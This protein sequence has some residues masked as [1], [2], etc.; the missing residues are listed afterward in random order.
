M[1]HLKGNRNYP[2]NYRPI[3]L[4]SSISTLYAR[5]LYRELKDHLE[6]NYKPSVKKG[7]AS[8]PS[9]YLYVIILCRKSLPT[10]LQE[11]DSHR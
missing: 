9:D 10:V 8:K 1:S 2:A 7:I 5:Q 3:S 4:L 6:Q 11:V